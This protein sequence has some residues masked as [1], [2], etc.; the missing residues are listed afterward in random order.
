[1]VFVLLVV[2]SSLKILNEAPFIIFIGRNRPRI[3]H[4]CLMKKKKR[5]DLAEK[6]Y[7]ILKM[8]PMVELMLQKK[9]TKKFLKISFHLHSLFENY[10]LSILLI[11]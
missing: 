3:N 10:N 5:K 2:Q 7:P 8:N 1:M 9:V 6:F 11:L 4:S